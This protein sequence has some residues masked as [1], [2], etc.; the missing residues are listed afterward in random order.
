MEI[1]NLMA[2]LELRQKSSKETHSE[3]QITL[4]ENNRLYIQL[5]DQRKVMEEYEKDKNSFNSKIISIVSENSFNKRKLD[6]LQKR[7]DSL[8]ENYKEALKRIDTLVLEDEIKT[9]SE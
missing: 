3:Y 5:S 9:K 2:M 4:E 6:E 1:A 8:E 7:Y